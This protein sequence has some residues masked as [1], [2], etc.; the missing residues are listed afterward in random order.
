MW[1]DF[2]QNSNFWVFQTSTLGWFPGLVAAPSLT[3]HPLCWSCLCSA[4]FRS[5]ATSWSWLLLVPHCHM[6]KYGWWRPMGWVNFLRRMIASYMHLS[7]KEIEDLPA[8]RLHFMLKDADVQIVLSN[9]LVEVD[10]SPAFN[11]KLQWRQP[12]ILR[13]AAASQTRNTRTQMLVR[14]PYFAG[15]RGGNLPGL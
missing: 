2:L 6:V 12:G 7:Q 4:S 13:L 8:E 15:L 9:R 14:C 3:G 5:S 11:M 1:D 10:S